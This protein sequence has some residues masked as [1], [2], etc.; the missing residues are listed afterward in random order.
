M[1]WT[2]GA[3]VIEGG[4]QKILILVSDTKA[5]TKADN[6]V[7]ELVSISGMGASKSTSEYGG[8]HYLQKKKT[9]GQ[10]TPNDISLT[11]NLTSEQLSAIRTKYDA[12]TKFYLAFARPDGTLILGVHG[13]ISSWGM[14]VNDGDTCKL[15]YSMALD[16][17]NV[18]DITVSVQ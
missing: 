13:Q 4:E 7:G 16:D 3:G 17:D 18:S 5:M 1:A 10:S 12:S 11:E 2:P 15:T 8:L 14:E 6:L 9:V